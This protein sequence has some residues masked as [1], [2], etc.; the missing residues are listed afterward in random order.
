MSTEL[1]GSDICK[2]IKE[3]SK[4]NVSSIK[5]GEISIEF[6]TTNNRFSSTIKSTEPVPPIDSKET[7]SILNKVN[8]EE[9]KEFEQAEFL[10]F[11]QAE[12]PTSFEENL[13]MGKYANEN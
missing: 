7:P 12:D 5:I 2:I 13:I 9:I 8:E 11:F 3:A 10:D 1:T 4:S 6:L